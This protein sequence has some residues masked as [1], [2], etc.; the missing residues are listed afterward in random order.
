MPDLNK[1]ALKRRAPEEEVRII[2]DKFPDMHGNPCSHH[3]D[4]CINNLLGYS[5]PMTGQIP[6]SQGHLVRNVRGSGAV[7]QQSSE[8]E[9]FSRWQ[10]KSF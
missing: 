5:V 8:S 7:F 4:L 9:A 1:S 2:A 10:K 3:T 6:L